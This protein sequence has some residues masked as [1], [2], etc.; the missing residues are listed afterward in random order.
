MDVVFHDAFDGVLCFC[1][2]VQTKKLF[3][4][5]T[6]QHVVGWLFHSASLKNDFWKQNV[7]MER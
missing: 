3:N 6:S 2:H 7:K 1:F 5:T 4:L